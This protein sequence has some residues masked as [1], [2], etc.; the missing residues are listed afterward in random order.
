[1]A[2]YG[3]RYMDWRYELCPECNDF[4]ATRPG[5][6]KE[7][8][9]HEIRFCEE[10]HASDHIPIVHCPLSEATHLHL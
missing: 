10:G 1:M 7:D 2:E 9:I 8:G 5:P 3:S 4:V 6:M